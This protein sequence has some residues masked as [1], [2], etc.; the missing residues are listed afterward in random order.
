MEEAKLTLFNLLRV[1][2]VLE[3]A[4]PGEYGPPVLIPQSLYDAAKSAGIDLTH[5]EPQKRIETDG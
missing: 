1:K 4:Q 2:Q 5:F 3:T